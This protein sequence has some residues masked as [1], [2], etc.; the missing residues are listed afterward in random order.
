VKKPDIKILVD[1]NWL[2]WECRDQRDADKLIA[3]T[4]AKLEHERKIINRF[5]QFGDDS[6]RLP[7]LPSIEQRR[8]RK[9]PTGRTG[10]PKTEK[11]GDPMWE[12]LWDV[13]LIQQIWLEHFGHWYRP[14]NDKV[15]AEQIAADRWDVDVDMV[16]NWV[17]KAKKP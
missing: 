11:H 17:K 2:R 14:K 1:G 5:I 12:A 6:P 10:R 7:L 8:R 15:R 4:K 3:W 16:C 9:L 13:E